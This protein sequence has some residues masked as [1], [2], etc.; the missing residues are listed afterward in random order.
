MI[1]HTPRST[2]YPTRRSSELETGELDEVAHGLFRRVVL[3]VGVRDERRGGIERQAGRHVRQPERQRQPVLQPLG[4]R[5]E[6]HTSELKSL[7]LIFS[8]LLF[9]NIHT[10]YI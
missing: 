2:P 9:H 3:P 7:A 10:P 5:S 1:R 8:R 4:H 6:E